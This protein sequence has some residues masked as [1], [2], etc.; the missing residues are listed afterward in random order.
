MI[1]NVRDGNNA[2]RRRGSN[3]PR[4]TTETRENAKIEKKI[5]VTLMRNYC[6]H[7]AEAESDEMFVFYR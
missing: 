7:R 2:A 1:M 6:I 4:N 5:N 3:E